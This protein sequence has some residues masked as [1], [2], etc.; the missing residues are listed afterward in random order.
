VPVPEVEAGLQA[1]IASGIDLMG[2]RKDPGEMTRNAAYAQQIRE[3]PLT[4][5]GG[6]RLDTLRELGEARARLGAV[7]DAGTLTVPV[8]LMH[9][10]EDDLAP[11]A[12]AR[13]AASRLPDARTAIFPKDRHNLLNELDRDEV[14]RV[15]IDFAR[16]VTA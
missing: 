10:E 9:G 11:V 4:W 3:D 14:Y 13:A 16:N 1:L 5:Q 12:G 15:L 7:V 2:L 6:I 8:L